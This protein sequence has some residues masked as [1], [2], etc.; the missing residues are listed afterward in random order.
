MQKSISRHTVQGLVVM[1]LQQCYQMLRQTLHYQ[2]RKVTAGQK[3]HSVLANPA[4]GFDW[5]FKYAPSFYIDGNNVQVLKEPSEFYNTLKVSTVWYNN[6]NK[7]LTLLEMRSLY[8]LSAL[9]L[10]I[11]TGI[12]KL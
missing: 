11:L 8:K 10:K 1:M 5:L 3:N 7:K 9:L 6:W 2:V 4:N 12:N